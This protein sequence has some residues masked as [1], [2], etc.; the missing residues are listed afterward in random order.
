ME[1][2][3][4]DTAL[5]EFLA[6]RGGDLTQSTLATLVDI[7]IGFF[8]TVPCDEL[9]PEPDSDM[10]LVQWGVYDW[11]Q[12]EQFEFDLT[13]QFISAA[14]GDD[15]AISQ[16]SLTMYFSPTPELRDVGADNRWCESRDGLAQFRDFIL[17]S[18]PYSLLAS[19]VPDASQIRWEQM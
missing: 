3:N 18:Q 13:R 7:G 12:G 15:E 11:G 4:S 19:Q 8:E 1:P 6:A 9:S 10:L 2:D 14:S 16:L 5:R 17:A